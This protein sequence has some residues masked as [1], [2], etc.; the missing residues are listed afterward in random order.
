MTTLYRSNNSP[1]VADPLDANPL[2]GLS[3]ILREMSAQVD[4]P[5]ANW[6]TI[7]EELPVGWKAMIP[8]PLVEELSWWINSTNDKTT[9]DDMSGVEGWR[10]VTI[11]LE[12]PLDGPSATS[13][14]GADLVKD[15][16][17]NGRRVRGRGQ[18]KVM[19]S[20]TL[21][22]V[23]T[24]GTG[25]K[26]R[27]ELSPK[28]TVDGRWT[29]RTRMRI[30]GGNSV[31]SQRLTIHSWHALYVGS[32]ATTSAT[33]PWLDEPKF[34]SFS[35]RNHE[36]ASLLCIPSGSGNDLLSDT[37]GSLSSA[38]VHNIG[39][40][41][42]KV[43]KVDRR[44]SGANSAQ[45]GIK[46]RSKNHKRLMSESPEIVKSRDYLSVAEARNMISG[47]GMRVQPALIG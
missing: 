14:L 47:N 37:S 30:P 15:S 46:R 39:K 38:T 28:V 23:A 13:V 29:T 3:A 25:R 41:M 44:R 40:P 1:R 26:V 19:T 31:Q 43:G 32:G 20:A 36:C 6:Q 22:R 16:T 45:V 17:T 18:V 4:D 42:T 35:G 12:S 2:R 8:K 21:L 11:G 33:A 24:N 5:T 7:S 9:L 27:R 34:R 10:Y